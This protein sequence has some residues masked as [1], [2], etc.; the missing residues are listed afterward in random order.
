MAY[1]LTKDE[2]KKL[3]MPAIQTIHVGKDIIA[4]LHP[5]DTNKCMVRMAIKQKYP[6][7]GVWVDGRTIRVK[8]DNVIHTAQT[9]QNVW[10]S[11]CAYDVGLWVGAFNFKLRIVSVKQSQPVPEHR[12]AQVNAARKKRAEEG[13]PDK[14]YYRIA[15]RQVTRREW[16][17]IR[18]K[19]KDDIET[20]L[21]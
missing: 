6:D 14:R 13:R 21:A 17:N 18:D 8:K 10:S 20:A 4:N 16:T 11:I 5:C 1:R 19:V 7:A 15:G 3:K 2:R 9:P 12:K